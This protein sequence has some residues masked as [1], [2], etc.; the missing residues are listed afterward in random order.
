[1]FWHRKKRTKI[2]VQENHIRRRY[3][4]YGHV[5]GVG[6]RWKCANLAR[7]YN[8]CGWVQNQE[9][10]TVILEVQGELIHIE[11]M[12]ADLRADRFI[13]IEAM[14]MTNISVVQNPEPFYVRY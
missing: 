14:D 10:G 8:V 6:F 5:Q 12:L 1:M 3:V 4:F 9:N 7:E 13:K 11:K 2:I